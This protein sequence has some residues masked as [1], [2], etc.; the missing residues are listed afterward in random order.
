[1]ALDTDT[2]TVAADT[3]RILDFT[4]EARRVRARAPQRPERTPDELLEDFACAVRRT[5]LADLATW[6]A[7]FQRR[8]HERIEALVGYVPFPRSP[9]DAGTAWNDFQRSRHFDE[10]TQPSAFRGCGCGCRGINDAVIG[11]I[12]SLRVQ[13][14]NVRAAAS[15]EARHSA[16]AA[17]ESHKDALLRTLWMY[18][19]RKI[20]RV[21]LRQ[22]VAEGAHSD[23]KELEGDYMVHSLGSA[24]RALASCQSRLRAG[25]YEK[26]PRKGQ[27]LDAKSL[28]TLRAEVKRW[29][30]EIPKRRAE[31]AALQALLADEHALVR[32]WTGCTRTAAVGGA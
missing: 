15:R 13:A 30:A 8:L 2:A 9:L 22:H 31:V 16:R 1:M 17:L 28:A 12:R 18:G 29:R 21:R 3:A 14:G 6:P 7:A 5:L 11:N 27:P 20:D 26:G 4:T 32:Q 24:R 19:H 23:L 25:V 10:T